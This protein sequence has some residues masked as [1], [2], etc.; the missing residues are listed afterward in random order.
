M[1]NSIAYLT[2]K[3]NFL[4]VS[5]EVPITKQRNADKFDAPDVFEGELLFSYFSVFNSVND[6]H[7]IANK[8]ELVTDLMVKAK[9]VEYLIQSL[10]E[11]EAEENQARMVLSNPYLSFIFNYTIVGLC[12][13]AR[14]QVLEDE[15]TIANEEYIQAVTRASRH[16]ILVVTNVSPYSC[17]VSRRSS[18]PGLRRLANYAQRSRHRR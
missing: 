15:M 16:P 1:A 10:P 3:S 5:P 7:V 9:Q 8:K 17:D 13:A 14:L 11:P 2:S 18:S 6:S 12:Q 4:Q